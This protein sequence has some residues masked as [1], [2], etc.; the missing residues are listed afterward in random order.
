VLFS[1][2]PPFLFFLQSVLEFLNADL[3]FHSVQVGFPVAAGHDVENAPLSPRLV[4]SVLLLFPPAVVVLVLFSWSYLTGLF[5]VGMEVL[6][7]GTVKA[8]IFALR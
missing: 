4:L 8:V 3:Q 6:F 5:N 1:S 2:P 7:G